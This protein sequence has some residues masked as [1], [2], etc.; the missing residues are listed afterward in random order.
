MSEPEWLDGPKFVAWLEGE[1]RFKAKPFGPAVQRRVS[2]WKAGSAVHVWKADEV[3][4]RVGLHLSM[5]PSAF[6]L[7]SYR[8]PG[9]RKTAV[10]YPEF[11]KRAAVDRA[12]RGVSLHQLE[13][14]IGAS[15]GTIKEWM[16]NKSLKGAR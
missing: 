6:W 4:T 12:E 15:R 3:L 8:G 11:V 13:R 2:D 5:L 16:R 14:E 9:K 7:N 1:Y 10:R